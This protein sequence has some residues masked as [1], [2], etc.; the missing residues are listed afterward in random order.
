MIRSCDRFFDLLALTFPDP[1]HS[2]SEEREITIGHS[3]GGQLLFVS[4]FE[5]GDRVRIISARSA[6]SMKKVSAKRATDDLR[7]EYDISQLEGG[8]RGKYFQRPTAGTNPVWIEPSLANVFPDAESVNRAL[9]LLVD[10]AE[11]AGG[12][13]HRAGQVHRRTRA[14]RKR[15]Q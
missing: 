12:Q 7:P 6:S 13:V 1:D 15:G 10:T 4:Y 3:I 14:S 2:G 5:R 11:A 9:R 8:V